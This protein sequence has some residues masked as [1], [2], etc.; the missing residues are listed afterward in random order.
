MGLFPVSPHR[1]AAIFHAEGGGNLSSGSTRQRHARGSFESD[2]FHEPSSVAGILREQFHLSRGHSVVICC[3]G[4]FHR[5]AR[6]T[7]TVLSRRSHSFVRRR[8]RP[9]SPPGCRGWCSPRP[10]A[11]RT[12]GV[13]VFAPSSTEWATR[14][15]R[16]WRVSPHAMAMSGKARPFG[17]TT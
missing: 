6:V 9:V 4:G 13:F 10:P 16:Q 11:E 1:I 7:K 5:K 3:A 15:R 12:P 2:L 14:E 8:R 17:G